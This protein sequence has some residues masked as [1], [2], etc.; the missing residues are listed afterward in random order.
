MNANIL[1]EHL[2]HD[3]GDH[4]L[5]EPV[6]KGDR[7]LPFA[8]HISAARISRRRSGLA[9]SR[10]SKDLQ[11][12]C[13]S[14]DGH[15]NCE[16]DTDMKQRQTDASTDFDFQ[17]GSWDV[18]HR[19]LNER[20]VSCTDWE[21]FDGTCTMAKVLGG[22]GNIEDNVL[23][24]SSGT[25]GAVALRSFDSKTQ[26]WAIWW[27]DAR[28]P[29]SLDVPVIGSFDG[30]VGTFYANDTFNGSPVRVR[31]LWLKTDLS[32]PRWEQAMSNDDGKTWETNWTM[33]FQRREIQAEK[34]SP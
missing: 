13:L 2:G 3:L 9:G 34:V 31:F 24:I 10:R 26:T 29:H 1:A 27:L 7:R 11:G 4:R 19:R 15:P 23:H 22:N 18:K 33:D 8:D 25:Y 28:S 5:F 32:S 20:L 16:E 17:I 12:A 14:C 21:E 6:V 30:G